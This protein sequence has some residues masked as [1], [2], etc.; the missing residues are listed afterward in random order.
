[1]VEKQRM[2]QEIHNAQMCIH[3]LEEKLK[4]KNVRD[5]ELETLKCKALEFEVFMRANSKSVDSSSQTSSLSNTPESATDTRRRSDESSKRSSQEKETKIRDEMAKIFATEMKSI[6][7]RFREELIYIEQR[8]S[9]TTKALEE[10]NEQMR[11]LKFT[12]LEERQESSKKL[13]EKDERLAVALGINNEEKEKNNQQIKC[14]I[15]EL[16]DKKALIEEE[17]LSIEHLKRQIKEEKEE[18]SK[19]KQEELSACNK[20]HE[21]T[22]RVINDL[23]EKYHV[24]KST[25]M[26]Y[27]KYSEEK[28]K[29][30]RS[31]FER[32]KAIY[33]EA[34][35][36]AKA[37]LKETQKHNKE[38]IK[39]MESDFQYKIEMLKGLI[40]NQK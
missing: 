16:N 10:R 7:Q 9:E 32:T 22:S 21:K 27:K 25:A 35:S 29:H 1:M 3:S 20:L 4:F 18:L 30:F 36:S 14:L 17:L 8:H 31:E 2:Q 34:V 28:E 23:T 26:N 40:S 15:A 33:L 6:E 38:V 24:A 12:I 11:L 39:S 5:E 13:K 37:E 19:R